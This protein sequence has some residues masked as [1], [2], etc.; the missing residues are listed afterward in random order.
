[1]GNVKVARILE[2]V[3]VMT[4]SLFT[5][6]LTASGTVQIDGTLNAKKATALT[7]KVNQLTTSAIV[8]SKGTLIIDGDLA[9]VNSAP[10][11]RAVSFIAEDVIIGG[12]RQWKLVR[13]EDF[14]GEN[15]A[16]GWSL[17]ETSSCSPKSRDHFLGGHCRIGDGEVSKRFHSLPPHSQLRVTARMHMIDNWQGETAFLK[18]DEHVVWAEHSLKTEPHVGLHVCGSDRFPEKRMS[19]PIDV[20]MRHEAAFIEVAFGSRA[21]PH[22]APEDPC[23]RSFGVDD[24]MLYVR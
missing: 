5:L 1:M 24:V 21:F 11:V 6:N 14:E 15:A 3:T 18:L 12:V 16:E 17:L 2:A 7:A 10:Q 4:D 20:S 23:D 8:P 19:I 22:N 9:I 13:H